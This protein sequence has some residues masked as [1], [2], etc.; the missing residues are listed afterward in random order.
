VSPEED[1]K[2]TSSPPG[3]RLSRDCHDG[4]SY[5]MED[6]QVEGLAAHQSNRDDQLNPS[7]HEST[8]HRKKVKIAREKRRRSRESDY[9]MVGGAT[10]TGTK[11]PDIGIGN[12]PEGKCQKRGG[13]A[14]PPMEE[15][16]S[17]GGGGLG[18]SKGEGPRGGL[19][20]SWETSSTLKGGRGHFGDRAI[21]LQSP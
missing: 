2:D 5:E 4:G 18:I 1:R 6:R 13:G 15:I 7:G 8:T 11:N 9:Q 10:E 14:I 12:T 3:S 19:S 17:G 20:D 21:L 16:R